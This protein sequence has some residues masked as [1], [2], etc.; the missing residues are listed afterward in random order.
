MAREKRD[1]SEYVIGIDGGASKSIAV[2]MNPEGRVTKWLRWKPINYHAAGIPE[3][4]K[5]FQ[6]LF[7]QFFKR[8]RIRAVVVGVAGLDTR[9]DFLVYQKILK[10]AIPRPVPFFVCNDTRTALEDACGENT[11]PRLIVIAGTGSN[12]YGEY[13]GEGA[14]SGGWDFLLADEGSAYGFGMAGIRAAIRS[15]DGRGEK[16]IL[17]RFVCKSGGAAD[18][19]SFITHIYGVWHKKPQE[20]KRFIAS[21]AKSVDRAAL[22]GD[23]VAK[24]IIR[25]DGVEELFLSVRAVMARLGIGKNSKLCVGYIGS[26]F[27]APG[28]KNQLSRRIKRNIP[29]AV[30]RH[31]VDA[32]RGAAKL[33]LKLIRRELPSHRDKITKVWA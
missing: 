4:R 7:S 6:Y 23:K 11:D 21:F 30:F 19:P 10:T 9:V 1:K 16:T 27:K 33:A 2:L 25:K 8:Y 29:H 32:A 3:T 15:F 24:N 31:E 28:L 18:I 20:F 14:R 26:N 22:R 5:H 12:V 17:E 13:R